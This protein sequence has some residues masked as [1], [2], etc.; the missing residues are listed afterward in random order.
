MKNINHYVSS[1]H[2]VIFKLTNKKKIKFVLSSSQ[3]YAADLKCPPSSVYTSF[4]VNVDN[5]VLILKVRRLK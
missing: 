3:G 5:Y 2:S 4:M 1:L